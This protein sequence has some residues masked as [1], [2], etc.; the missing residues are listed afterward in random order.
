MTDPD[1]PTALLTWDQTPGD[2]RQR[3]EAVL[4]A[5]GLNR[6]HRTE[7]NLLE[8]E[9]KAVL[10]TMYDE[11]Y[12]SRHDRAV[13]ILSAAA[14]A[15]NAHAKREAETRDWPPADCRMP[16]GGLDCKVTARCVCIAGVCAHAGRER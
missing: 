14:D 6:A 11:L 13:A 3:M 4:T 1:L 16:N 2:N 12:T 8:A 7:E 10:R 15:R 9:I 5:V